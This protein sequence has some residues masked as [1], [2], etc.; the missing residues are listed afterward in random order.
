MPARV[1]TGIRVNRA[2]AVPDPVRD[3]EQDGM[4]AILLESTSLLVDI[5]HADDDDLPP[6]W[7]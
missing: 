7:D 3:A 2:A 4:T 6:F 5:A 1:G